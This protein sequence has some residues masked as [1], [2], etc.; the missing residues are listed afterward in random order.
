MRPLFLLPFLLFSLV[1][2]KS[3]EE[4]LKAAEEKGRELADT[5]ARLVKGVGESLKTEGKAGAEAL[6]QGVGEVVKG[7]GK[8]FDASLN[9]VKV[10]VSQTLSAKGL[11]ATRASKKEHTIAV[12]VI[13]DQGFSGALILR[14]L[15]SKQVEVGRATVK[16]NETAGAARYVEFPFDAHTPMAAVASFELR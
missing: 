3:R 15:D 11:Q 5:K 14:A 8:G 6:T 7:V 9:E 2:C 1:A 13:L 16:V 12:Y 4:K 10:S